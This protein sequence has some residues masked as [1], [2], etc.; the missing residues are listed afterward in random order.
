MGRTTHLPHLA[1]VTRTPSPRPTPEHRPDPLGGSCVMT[2]G[3]GEGGS[4]LRLSDLSTQFKQRWI[5]R[6]TSRDSRSKPRW[7]ASPYLH[8]LSRAPPTKRLHY[9][10]GSTPS[11]STPSSYLPLLLE[12]DAL[13]LQASHSAGE[14]DPGRAIREVS[15]S[16]VVLHFRHLP[17]EVG[18]RGGSVSVDG[19]EKGARPAHLPMHMRVVGCSPCLRTTPR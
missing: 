1:T 17:R 12:Q 6:N 2:G 16:P 4:C 5:C 15:V 8:S 3:D 7:I 10:K 13:P 9:L 19:R 14:L 11:S 18:R